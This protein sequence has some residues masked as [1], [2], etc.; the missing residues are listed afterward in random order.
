MKA[1]NIRTVVLALFVGVLLFTSCENEAAPNN[2]NYTSTSGDLETRISSTQGEDSTVS[3]I[4]RL[5]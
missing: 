1:F 4:I 3:S 2:P 5:N